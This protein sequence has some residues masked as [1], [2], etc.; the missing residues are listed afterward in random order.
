MRG[1]PSPSCLASR[2]T[3]IQDNSST[4]LDGPPVFTVPTHWLLSSALYFDQF[5]AKVVS[6][7]R[8][9]PMQASLSRPAEMAYWDAALQ[10]VVTSS[11]GGASASATATCSPSNSGAAAI[12]LNVDIL[13]PD[14]SCDHGKGQ[15]SKSP[16]CQS[17][18][19][20]L[21]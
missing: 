9:S 10:V 14:Y 18:L 5:W 20:R 19:L 8:S 12:L 13:Y 7:V 21:W 2:N 11:L 6:A 1:S 3:S 17:H 15:S 16:G 4:S